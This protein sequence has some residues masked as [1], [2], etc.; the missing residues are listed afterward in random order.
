MNIEQKLEAKE[1]FYKKSAILE[2][3]LKEIRADEQ[4]LRF[5]QEYWSL[6]KRETRASDI[7]LVSGSENF[8]DR[9]NDAVK[10]FRGRS[11]TNIS[12]ENI[13]E[14]ASDIGV[15]DIIKKHAKDFTPEFANAFN[16]FHII[17]NR[18]SNLM[19]LNSTIEYIV[20]DTLKSVAQNIF[21]KRESRMSHKEMC[22]LFDRAMSGNMSLAGLSAERTGVIIGDCGREFEVSVSPINNGDSAKITITHDGKLYTPIIDGEPYPSEIRVKD[23]VPFRTD[24]DEPSKINVVTTGFHVNGLEARTDVIKPNGGRQIGPSPDYDKPVYENPDNKELMERFMENLEKFDKGL[25]ITHTFFLR[26]EE[27]DQPNL[28]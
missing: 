2:A 15:K 14:F 19:I 4:A 6:R 25:P 17:G 1:I 5:R 24:E 26:S 8:N 23:Q 9:F 18:I 28:N 10:Y 27:L 20:K 22:K 16:P 13:D 12:P 3:F 7:Q 21:G 11:G